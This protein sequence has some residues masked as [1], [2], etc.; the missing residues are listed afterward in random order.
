MKI[1]ISMLFISQLFAVECIQLVFSDT[2]LEPLADGYFITDPTIKRRDLE[3]KKVFMNTE[4]E[5]SFTYEKIITHD[6]LRESSRYA[7]KFPYFIE[8]SHMEMEDQPFFGMNIIVRSS[9]AEM[10]R[11]FLIGAKTVITPTIGNCLGLKEQFQY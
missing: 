5:T 11:A 8:P 2:K 1:L 4:F 6:Y 3:G 7:G 9:R 10:L